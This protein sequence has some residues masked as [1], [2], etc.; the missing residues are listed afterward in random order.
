MFHIPAQV[1]I[2]FC[3]LVYLGVRRC[4]ARTIRP[5]RTLVFPL[6]FVVLGAASLQRLFPAP[7]PPAQ[8]LALAAIVLSAGIGWLH[9]SRWRLQFEHT[10]AG[11]QVRLPGDPTLLV[12]LLLS[13]FIKF[14]QHYALAVHAAW[15]T[16]NTFEILSF[17]AWGALAGMPLGRSVNVLVRAMRARQR[18]MAAPTWE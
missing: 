5:E 12:T 13:F 3:A 6:A 15:S 2:L 8:A 10:G 17:A 4:F 18:D 16:T 9:A 14:A 1:Y 11:L 7:H